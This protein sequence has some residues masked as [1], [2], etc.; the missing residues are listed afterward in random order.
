MEYVTFVPS[1]SKLSIITMVHDSGYTCVF[2]PLIPSNSPFP[3]SPS[4]FVILSSVGQFKLKVIVSF[5]KRDYID[6][7]RFYPV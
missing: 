6:K 4:N 3:S 1:L 2:F 7:T 5:M